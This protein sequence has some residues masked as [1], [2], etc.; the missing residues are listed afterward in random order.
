MRD[1]VRFNSGA[2]DGRVCGEGQIS[3][4]DADLGLIRQVITPLQKD[5]L[6]GD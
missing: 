3:L 1:K 5:I 6:S 4:P 2:A